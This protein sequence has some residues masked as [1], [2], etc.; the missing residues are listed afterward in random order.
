MKGSFVKSV[1]LI[2]IR[3][4]IPVVDTLIRHLMR[5]KVDSDTARAARSDKSEAAAR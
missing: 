1:G 5:M 3:L 4:D 2:T